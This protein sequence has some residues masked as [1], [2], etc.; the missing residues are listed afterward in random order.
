[1][2]AAVLLFCFIYF[3]ACP[4]MTNIEINLE[5]TEALI[6]WIISDHVTYVITQS[7][8]VDNRVSPP[9]INTTVNDPLSVNPATVDIPKGATQYR[10]DFF[11]YEGTG[12]VMSYAQSNG[13]LIT[14][15]GKTLYSFM[16]QMTYS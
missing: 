3:A 12:L 14:R 13:T 6:S 8:D 1:M 7:C 2:R 9:C 4:E 5:E 11:L 15:P 16:Q 10:F